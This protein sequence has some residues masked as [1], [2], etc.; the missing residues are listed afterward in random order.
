V[1]TV[2]PILFFLF[3]SWGVYRWKFFNIQGLSRKFLVTAFITKVIAGI[4][5]TTIYTH[6]YDV[7][8]EA[9]TFRYFDDSYHLH[10]AAFEN[11]KA[12]IRML[13]GIDD[14]KDLMPYL[15][16]M[17]NW[18]PAE[19]T[20]FYNDNRTVIRINALIRWFSFGSYYVH[21]LI[22]TFLAFYG[23]TFIYKAFHRYF[24]G[25]KIW[26]GLI[27]FFTPSIVFWSSGILKEGP[28]FF[29]LGIALNILNKIFTKK[30]YWQ[31]YTLL[32]FCFLFLFHLKFY[33]GLLLVPA[34]TGYLWIIKQKGPHPI[35]KTILNFAIYYSIA[36]IWH[37]YNLNWSLFTVL[38]WKRQDF[39]GLAESMNAKSLIETGNLENTPISFLQNFSWGLFNAIVRP[40]PW[41]VYSIVLL[42]NAIEN[43]LIILFIFI[44]LVYGKRKNFQSIGYFFLMYAFALLTII[45]MVTPIMGSLVRYKIPAIPFL[46]MFFLL[47]MEKEKGKKL[48]SLFNKRTA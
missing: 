4:T 14:G 41:E 44:C 25:K 28:L 7:R 20:T 34:T 40:L 33:V 29:V 47:F 42:P 19:R 16:S 39:L 36:V 9:D 35:I 46:L 24:P 23:L 22:F 43:C 21:L 2:L 17:N 38:K 30:A 6:Y 11:P 10:K 1:N 27:L 26:L 15:D 18:F 13:F 5:L 48:I 45:G 8:F 3:F 31:H 32:I 37:L 12:Y